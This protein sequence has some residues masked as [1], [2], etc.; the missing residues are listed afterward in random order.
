[1][2]TKVIK[3]DRYEEL[4]KAAEENHGYCPC[5]VEKNEDTKCMC[6]T[7]REQVKLGQLGKCYCGMYEIVEASEE[8]SEVRTETHPARYCG[9]YECWDVLEDRLEHKKFTPFQAFLYGCAFK[10]LWRLGEKDEPR[11]EI[12]KLMNYLEKL[13]SEVK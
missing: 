9:K 1:M 5:A 7:F 3:T 6:K 4:K 11:K 12:D 2:K 13:K 10:Y 8:S